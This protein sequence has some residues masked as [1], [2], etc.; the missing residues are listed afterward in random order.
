MRSLRL[1][2]TALGAVATL[3]YLITRAPGLFYTDTGELAAACATLGVA[4][5]TGYP[6][7]T[8]LGHAWSMLPWPSVIIGLGI[9]NA[10]V[11]GVGVTVLAYVVRDVLRRIGHPD[12]APTMFISLGAAGLAG[13]SAVAWDVA[14]AFEV[15]GLHILLLSLTLFCTMRSTLDK[16]RQGAWTLLA[17]LCFGLML[18]NH[19]S[20]AFLAPGLLTLWVMASDDPRARRTPR[21]IA[22]VVLPAVAALAL[23]AYLP[24]RSAQHPPIDWGGTAESF[25]HFWY[26]V[27]GT[28]FGVWLFSNDKAM[29]ENWKVFTG[30]VAGMTLWVGL[31]PM[32]IGLW[33]SLTGAR[34]VGLGLLVMSVGN[35]GISLGYAI[36]DIDAYFLP[37]LCVLAVMT[38]IGARRLAD[39]TAWMSYVMLALPLIGIGV[40]Y[41]D[42]DR[43]DHRAVEAYTRWVLE[44]AEPNAVIISHQWD[45]FCSAFWYLQTVEGVRP[46][47]TLIDKELLRRTWYLPYLQRRYPATMKGMQGAVGGFMPLLTRFER[48]GDDFM[49]DRVAVAAIQDRFV[50]VLNA[51]LHTNDE[52]PL[53]VTPEMMNEERGFGNGYAPTPAGPLVRL[54]R[55]TPVE[56][57]IRLAQVDE[58][59]RSLDGRT[60]RLDNGLRGMVALVLAQ[61]ADYALRVKQDTATYAR[62][63][64]VVQRIDPGGPH[65]RYLESLLPRP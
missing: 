51:L 14:T 17:G 48:E 54:H 60:E 42:R 46:D 34:R 61:S 56:Q 20:S 57:P 21:A 45:Y 30:H 29:A 58:I 55:T 39:R 6:L 41:A 9:L 19:L 32:A 27:R 31:L 64:N 50:E 2:P 40:Q 36:P 53:Y 44:N 47:V 1:L 12:D 22:Y 4:H 15:Y 63:R 28:Q 26:H 16:E 7:F 25:H 5:P 62:L 65:L 11:V 24:L 3:V 37:S 13:F 18:T 49:R 35:L 33:A 59:I 43:S 23:Y 10:L 52:R 8:L 38:A